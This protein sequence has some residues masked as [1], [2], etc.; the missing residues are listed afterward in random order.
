MAVK[1]KVPEGC[2][3]FSY[4]GAEF[5]PNKKGVAVV[6]EQAIEALRAHGIVPADEAA[7]D[8]GE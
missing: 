6:P 8:S 1:V 3:S 5:I 7:A 4:D 2:G